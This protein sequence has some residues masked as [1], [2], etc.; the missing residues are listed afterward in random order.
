MASAVS[1]RMPGA[2]A[3]PEGVEFAKGGLARYNLVYATVGQHRDLALDL[4]TPAESRW[5]GPRPTVVY[6]HG[7]GFAAFDKT[8]VLPTLGFRNP[9]S[10]F[11]DL[12]DRGYAVASLDYR[13]SGEAQFPLPLHDVKAGVRWLR[14]KAKE[15]N[16]DPD[17]FASWGESAGGWFSAMLAATGDHPDLEGDQGVTGVSSRVQAAVDWYGPTD[18][19]RM[20]DHLIR[21]VLLRHDIENSPE[22]HFLGVVPSQSPDLNRAASPLTYITPDTAPMLIQHGA[23]DHI[24]APDQSILLDRALTTAQVPHQLIIYPRADHMFLG[25]GFLHPSRITTPFFAFLDTH[26]SPDR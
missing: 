13:L 22:T 19:A 12:V 6:I 17:R 16:L 5:P 2:S 11:A 7:G 25:Y 9:V 8:G 20:D 26:L 18:F 15:F 3:G 10:L 14:S 21:P 24:V 4:Y 23:F 1:R